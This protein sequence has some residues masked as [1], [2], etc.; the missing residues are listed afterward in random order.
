[1]QHVLQIGCRCG[2]DDDWPCFKHS[3][4]ARGIL[5][6]WLEDPDESAGGS[7]TA[8]LRRADVL[9]MTKKMSVGEHCFR[10]A[11]AMGLRRKY[12][13]LFGAGWLSREDSEMRDRAHRAACLHHGWQPPKSPEFFGYSDGWEKFGDQLIEVHD[14][15]VQKG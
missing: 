4:E 14:A 7:V 15:V 5:I 6:G 2:T 11:A 10:R 13:N 9:A 8:V 3:K 12:S 1:M